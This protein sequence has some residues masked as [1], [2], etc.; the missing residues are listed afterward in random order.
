MKKEKEKRKRKNGT[1]R[2]KLSMC[3]LILFKYM[4]QNCISYVLLHTKYKMDLLSN[5]LIYICIY[6]YRYIYTGMLNRIILLLNRPTFDDK[7]DNHDE[8]TMST[9]LQSIGLSSRN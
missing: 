6:I 9:K 4:F 7:Y 8:N 3:Q 1:K 2:I 5:M